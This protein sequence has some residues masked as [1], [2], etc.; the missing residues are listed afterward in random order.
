MSKIL[1]ADNE[2][3]QRLLLCEILLAFEPTSMVMEARDGL[4]AL[5]L[6]QAEKP[7]IVLLGA[8]MPRID[9]ITV[10]KLIKADPA[11]HTIPVVM[12]VLPE[13]VYNIE[14]EAVGHSGYII[15]PIDPDQLLEAVHAGQAQQYSFLQG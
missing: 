15:K 5:E 2:A 9:G 3:L 10:C 7:D 6:I 8:R 1:V 4:Q 11:L 13:D 12:I 14:A